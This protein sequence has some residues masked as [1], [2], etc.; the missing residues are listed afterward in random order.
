MEYRG[1]KY[2]LKKQENIKNCFKNL[3][4]YSGSLMLNK[5]NNKVDVFLCYIMILLYYHTEILS[6]NGCVYKRDREIFV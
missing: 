2:L 1:K 5:N 6:F 4:N 3:Y